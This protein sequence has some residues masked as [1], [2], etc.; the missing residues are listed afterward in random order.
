ME[1]NQDPRA[2]ARRLSIVR[3]LA[4]TAAAVFAA[5]LLARLIPPLAG[6]V[7]LG[8]ASLLPALVVL[9]LMVL[10]QMATRFRA[11]VF[12]PTAGQET[13]FLIVNQRAITNTVEQ[14]AVFAPAQLVLATGSPR[15]TVAFGIVFA[16]GRI[17][18]WG[19]YLRA[20]L[21]RAPGMAATAVATT[22]ALVGAVMT[23]W[24]G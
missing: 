1:A 9:W 11:G 17:A 23:C 22:L 4:G 19:G 21:A 15:W 3:G 20:P 6:S 24:P 16:L 14:L 18:F 2:A 7:W 13:R 8:A 12:D 5:W 10:A